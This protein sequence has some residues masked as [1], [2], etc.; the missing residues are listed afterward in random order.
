MCRWVNC[1]T[2]FFRDP[3]VFDL[4]VEAIA[5]VEKTGRRA[6]I[7][8]MGCSTGQEPLSI[9]MVFAER[10]ET[11]GTPIPEIVATDVSDA[12]VIRAR[13]GCY[14]QF[15]IQRGLSVRRMINWFDAV[16]D[17]SHG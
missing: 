5:M 7:W 3:H 13:A 10:N 4:I 2:S 12:A 14:T 9:A 11:L 1:E 17:E 6:R 15:E 8:S 16:G